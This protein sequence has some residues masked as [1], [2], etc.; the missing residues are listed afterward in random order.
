V[1]VQRAR[2]GVDEEVD[3]FVAFKAPVVGDR[4]GCSGRVDGRAIAW[5]E[6]QRGGAERGIVGAQNVAGCSV[7]ASFALTVN[8][9]SRP[10][11]PS[12]KP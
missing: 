2:Q 9:V 5:I 3:R 1:A 11:V 12:R 7:P 6:A 10:V 4:Q 8:R